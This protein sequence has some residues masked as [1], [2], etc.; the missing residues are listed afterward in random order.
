MS[1]ES[2]DEQVLDTFDLALAAKLLSQ[3]SQVVC[4]D[5]TLAGSERILVISGPLHRLFRGRR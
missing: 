3:D 2:K 1:V 5:L 4:N